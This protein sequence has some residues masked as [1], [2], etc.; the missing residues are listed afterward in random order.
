MRALRVM[1]R[2]CQQTGKRLRELKELIRM[3]VARLKDEVQSE[4][5]EYDPCTSTVCD[6]LA[7]VRNRGAR[8]ESHEAKLPDA[9]LAQA[10]M[11]EKLRHAGPSC[12][13]CAI[14]AH[15]T[16]RN[17]KISRYLEL[18]LNHFH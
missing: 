12:R 10:M 3:Q 14:H 1:T 8:D 16:T 15:R 17:L 5:H 11:T 9:Y 2:R 4:Q 13:H 6:D 7:C 18:D